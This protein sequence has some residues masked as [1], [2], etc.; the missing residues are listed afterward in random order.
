MK[1]KELIKLLADRNEDLREE[2]AELMRKLIKAYER[3]LA[4]PEAGRV[5]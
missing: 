2:N 1:K 4:A 5:P 3:L